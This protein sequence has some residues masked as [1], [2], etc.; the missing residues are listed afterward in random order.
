M[1]KKCHNYRLQASLAYGT[2]RKGHEVDIVQDLTVQY[3]Y[4]S[5]SFLFNVNKECSD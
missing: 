3:R 1:A 5:S 4:I 2:A